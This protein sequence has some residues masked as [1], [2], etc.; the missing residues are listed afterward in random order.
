MAEK[1]T[2]KICLGEEKEA[3]GKRRE[4][5]TDD[6]LFREDVSLWTVVGQGGL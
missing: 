6:R 4:R 3:G 1:E 2:P 5:T